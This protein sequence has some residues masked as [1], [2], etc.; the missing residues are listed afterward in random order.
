[1]LACGAECGP[2]SLFRSLKVSIADRV[3]V[4]KS[5]VAW[6]L[7]RRVGIRC[8]RQSIATPG[9]LDVIFG[10]Q[11]RK[12]EDTKR[13]RL[14][15]TLPFAVTEIHATEIMLKTV[16]DWSLAELAYTHP[17]VKELVKTELGQTVGRDPN[18]IHHL[19]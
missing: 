16:G 18:G 14:W 9:D 12:T 5:I 10:A 11:V 17:L 13:H 4:V 8:G 19:V 1:V 7:A 15:R 3:T 6:R 2:L